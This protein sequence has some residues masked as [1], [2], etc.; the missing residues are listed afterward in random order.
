MESYGWG[1][2]CSAAGGRGPAAFH[3]KRGGYDWLTLLADLNLNYARGRRTVVTGAATSSPSPLC[4]R[5][6]LNTMCNLIR[7][8]GLLIR[9]SPSGSIVAA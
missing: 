6:E 8:L 5:V 3:S 7:A 4:A 9:V 1:S 2:G